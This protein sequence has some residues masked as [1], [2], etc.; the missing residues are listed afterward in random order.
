M[1]SVAELVA[2]VK[3]SPGT[4]CATSGVG[5]NQHVLMEWFNKTAD[6]KLDHVPY[7]GAGQAIND[8]VAGHV[9][10]A[11]LGPTATLPHA[12]RQ[13]DQAAGAIRRSALSE[14]ARPADLAG[15]RLSGRGAGILVRGICAARHASRHHRAAQCR[16]RQG[17]ARQGFARR[18]VQGRNRA[19][20]RRPEKLAKLARDDSDKYA[21]IVREANIK[22]GG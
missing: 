19:G 17:D 1:K 14:H 8:L 2:A 9:K 12:A 11:F 22:V 6:I 20:R 18:L 4:G 7:R 21:R 13:H 10:V 16:I 15:G 3:K 5:S